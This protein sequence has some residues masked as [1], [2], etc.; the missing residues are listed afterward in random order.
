[1][2]TKK[3]KGRGDTK[4]LAFTLLSNG[5]AYKLIRRLVTAC[6]ADRATGAELA[7]LHEWNPH[8]G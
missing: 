2:V 8:K 3:E 4:T 5:S 7:Q 6:W 1:M